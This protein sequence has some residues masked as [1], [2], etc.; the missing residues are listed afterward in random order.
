[1]GESSFTERYLLCWN[2]SDNPE[3]PPQ[4]NPLWSQWKEFVHDVLRKE[5]L[6]FKENWD[7]QLMLDN[8][9]LG[10]LGFPARLSEEGF[11]PVRW[12]NGLIIY[13]KKISQPPPAK[14]KLHIVESRAAPKDLHL[15]RNG[16][17][18]TKPYKQNNIGRTYSVSRTVQKKLQQRKSL[19]REGTRRSKRIQGQ[20]P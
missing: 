20:A 18:R 1:M 11:Q 8:T 6:V 10:Q 5:G 17:V 13:H 14:K 7:A 15:S 3:E 4:Q 9:F 16:Y 2:T 12:Q 19:D